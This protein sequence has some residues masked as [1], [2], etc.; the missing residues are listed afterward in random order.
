MVHQLDVAGLSRF[1]APTVRRPRIDDAFFVAR[2]DV[3][4]ALY[5]HGATGG[6]T[7]LC[8]D[9]DDGPRV[10]VPDGAHK[11]TEPVPL[12]E[13]RVLCSLVSPAG[14]PAHPSR[15]VRIEDG[16][17]TSGCDGQ[18]L[19]LSADKAFAIVVDVDGRAV[20]RWTLETGAVA[21]IFPLSGGLFAERALPPAL[22]PDG[23]RALVFDVEDDVGVLRAIATAEDLA[24]VEILRVPAPGWATGAFGPQGDVVVLA[25][26]PGETPRARVLRGRLGKSLEA[27][28]ELKV[29]QPASIPVVTAEG[30]VLPF[31][32]QAHP[33]SSYGDV[34]LVAIARGGATQVIAPGVRGQA[35]AAEDGVV[36]EGGRTLVVVPTV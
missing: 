24:A 26:E 12:G 22:A 4:G 25:V 19:G 32:L 17:I 11:H 7:G 31:S 27:V 23:D 21:D 5:A 33:F 1:G 35:R 9:D 20:R 16:G 36:V 18:T 10:V 13:G 6:V 29:E 3:T 34:D 2:D 15:F 14:A 30:I 28:L 8:V